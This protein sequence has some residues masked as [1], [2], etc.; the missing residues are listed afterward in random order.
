MQRP[1]LCVIAFPMT[2]VLHVARVG[3][4][5]SLAWLGLMTVASVS[6]AHAASIRERH[7]LDIEAVGSAG[8]LNAVLVVPQQ[9]VAVF[10]PTATAGAT[11]VPVNNSASGVSVDVATMAAVLPFMMLIDYSSRIGARKA[12]A[13]EAGALLAHLDGAQRTWKR[14][15]WIEELGQAI[16]SSDLGTSDVQVVTQL[17][18]A[19]Q[20]IIKRCIKSNHCLIATSVW[21]LSQHA[22]NLEAEVLLQ[23][24]SRTIR[25]EIKGDTRHL[26]A[27]GRK[28]KNYVRNADYYTLLRY[29]SE[30]LSLPSEKTA[31][32]RVALEEAVN[33]MYQHYRLPELIEIAK[34]GRRHEVVK[35]KQ[36]AAPR[37]SD[38]R[39]LKSQVAEENWQYLDAMHRRAQ[40]WAQNG[41]APLQEKLD[42]ALIELTA[43]IPLELSR[44]NATRK[45]KL[46]VSRWKGTYF[47][48]VLENAPRP[49]GF[50]SDG[51]LVSAQMDDFDRPFAVSWYESADP[52]SRRTPVLENEE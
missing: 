16:K 15:R 36:I 38:Y 12:L 29:R 23:I 32:D 20:E 10:W 45:S 30:A 48:D 50:L 39:A 41:A 31:Q 51:S 43:L 26:T 13:R 35:A 27:S 40:L 22:S 46:K 14:T 4:L 34:K 17:D 8:P 49:R 25:T 24:W 11:V 7:I 21:G 18:E 9:R 3:K 52:G 5:A 19:G 37:L 33:L 47:A 42:E 28:K 2:A 1:S 6:D 44:S